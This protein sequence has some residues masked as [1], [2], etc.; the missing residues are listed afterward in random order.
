[1]Y[2]FV[3]ILKIEIQ[4]NDRFFQFFP[5][6]GL[7]FALRNNNRIFSPMERLKSFSPQ[8]PYQLISGITGCWKVMTFLK[9]NR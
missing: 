8:L 6:Y 5:P 9:Y 4:K 2:N 7:I 1:M 3:L